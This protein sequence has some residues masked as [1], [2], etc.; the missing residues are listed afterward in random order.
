MCPNSEYNR[1]HV[2]KS[3]C[4]LPP[5]CPI[6]F[7]LYGYNTWSCVI[8]WW[9]PG[10]TLF[11]LSEASSVFSTNTNKKKKVSEPKGGEDCHRISA[12]ALL[13]Y[14]PIS[15]RSAVSDSLGSDAAVKLRSREKMGH[16]LIGESP[17]RGENHEAIGE[18]VSS[19]LLHNVWSQDCVY[20]DPIS[21]VMK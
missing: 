17:W 10:F 12:R 20:I 9:R 15:L 14:L 16:V 11:F 3:C 7:Y 13:N 6:Q 2:K 21:N 8:T 5:F 1:L 19:S 18:T 4:Y